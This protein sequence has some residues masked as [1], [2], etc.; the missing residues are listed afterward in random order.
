MKYKIPQMEI[1][2]L[3]EDDVVTASLNVGETANETGD[4]DSTT[5]TIGQW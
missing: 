3:E 4:S 2:R 5:G 1:I